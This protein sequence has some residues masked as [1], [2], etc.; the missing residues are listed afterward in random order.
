MN[1]GLTDS[2]RED[3]PD[4]LPVERPKLLNQEIKDPYWVSGFVNGEGCFFIQAYKSKTKTGILKLKFQVSQH[5]RDA[6]LMKNLVSYFGCGRCYI[7]KNKNSDVV[8]FVVEK[9]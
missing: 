9:I 2:L 7:R 1:L 4:I 6:E 8:D 3:F 5:A